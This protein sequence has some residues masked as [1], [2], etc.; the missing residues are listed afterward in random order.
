MILARANQEGRVLVT[1][2]KDFG[3]LGVLRNVP[4]QGIVRLVNFRSHQQGRACAEILAHY[5]SE[6]ARAAI[7]T[8]E[9]GRIRI[10]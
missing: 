6:L 9:P 3:E 1:L 4:H 8:A 10:R 5:A 7:I 2:D